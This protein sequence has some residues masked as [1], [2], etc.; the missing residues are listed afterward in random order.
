MS[1]S[2]ILI[3][4]DMVDAIALGGCLLGGGGGGSMAEGIKLAMA[5]LKHGKVLLKDINAIDPESVVLT[6]SAVGAPSSSE[7]FVTDQDH[8]RTV[9]LCQAVGVSGI[10]AFITNECGGGSIFNGWVPAAILGL[11]L[12]DAPCNG[13]AHPTG[14]MGSMGLHR[15]KDYVSVQSAVGG[16]P[17]TGKHLEA[18][19]K[20]TLD[21]ASSLVRQ[22]AVY[23]GGLVAVARNP[24]KA[25]FIKDHGAP[26][27]IKLA[28]KLGEAMMKLKSSGPQAVASTSMDIL[29]GNVITASRVRD[30]KLVS[31]GGFDHGKIVLEDGHEITFWNE[32][33]TLECNG[34]RISTFPDLIMTLDGESGV[35][36]TSAEVRKDQMVIV[37]SAS[38]KNLILGEGMRCKELFEPIEKV[39]GK[40]IISYLTL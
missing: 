17:K 5:A 6:S 21:S 10:N 40:E 1:N 35:P 13:R 12:L 2:D 25:S 34:K 28:L 4:E 32:Y 31:E 38:A 39:I 30:K 14:L 29:G 19:F 20:G 7:A 26:G 15:I 36:A 11:P 24:V 8:Q 9:E 37:V 18:V 23:A 33:M 22:C 27:A 16:N 3:T